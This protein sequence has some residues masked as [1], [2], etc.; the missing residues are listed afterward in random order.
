MPPH[1]QGPAIPTTSTSPRTPPTAT[2]PGSAAA[3]NSPAKRILSLGASVQSSVLLC[4]SAK[5]ILP[6]VDVAIFADT[7]WEPK[8]EPVR[9]DFGLTA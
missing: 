5:G 8:P 7:G 2:S 3:A 9:D 4:L 6:R 1:P